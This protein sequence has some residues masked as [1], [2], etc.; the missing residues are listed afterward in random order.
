MISDAH[1]STEK[2]GRLFFKRTAAF[3]RED[4]DWGA[5][6]LARAPKDIVHFLFA[7][8][9]NAEGCLSCRSKRTNGR[10]LILDTTHY[11]RLFGEKQGSKRRRNSTPVK[12][13]CAVLLCRW[14][15]QT[16]PPDNRKGQRPVC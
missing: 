12:T 2:A 9:S 14:F 6:L 11:I 13:G 5:G 16:E 7:D 4:R 8:A 3:F 10:T 15:I 1:T